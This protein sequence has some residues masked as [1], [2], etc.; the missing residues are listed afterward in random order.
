[1]PTACTRHCMCYAG[2]ARLVVCY[3]FTPQRLCER[4]KLRR[5]PRWPRVIVVLQVL[6]GQSPSLDA[7]Q[8]ASMI[9]GDRQKTPRRACREVTACS[10]ARLLRCD[11]HEPCRS[12][13]PS[14]FARGH[15]FRLALCESEWHCLL[16]CSRASMVDGGDQV[17][18]QL[19]SREHCASARAPILTGPSTSC[20]H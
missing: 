17:V 7:N 15:L 5:R 10:R 6:E 3:C 20:A 2:P 4:C 18:L 9:C 19:H 8:T 13:A 11:L 1:M 16:H 12:T 14:N